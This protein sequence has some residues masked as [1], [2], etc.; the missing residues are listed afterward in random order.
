M[1]TKFKPEDIL[2]EIVLAT[3]DQGFPPSL[4]EIAMRTGRSVAGVKHH[5]DALDKSKL[6]TWER[7]SARTVRLTD[8][9][10][11]VV[12]EG[13]SARA[14]VRRLVNGWA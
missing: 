1:K 12:R 7:G 11:T 10:R 9:G 8:E 5:I 4:R 6:I 13:A 3:A 2:T 14:D